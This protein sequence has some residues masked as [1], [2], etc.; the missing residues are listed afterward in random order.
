MK[1]KRLI[2]WGRA[3]Y[4]SSL[5]QCRTAREKCLRSIWLSASAFWAI[6]GSDRV[7]RKTWFLRMRACNR[8]PVYDHRLKRCH[9]S[10]QT[11]PENGVERPFGC[12]CYMPVKATLKEAECWLVRFGKDQ[13]G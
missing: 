4:L 1:L 11:Y 5:S 12:G 3:L 10:F 8:C 2:E 6:R 9:N 7:D 13:W